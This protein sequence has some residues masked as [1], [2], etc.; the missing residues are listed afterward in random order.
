MLLRVA[1]E[2]PYT[3]FCRVSTTNG[4]DSSSG[5]LVALAFE[6]PAKENHGA[7]GY[8]HLLDADR[9]HQCRGRVGSRCEVGARLDMS[10][11]VACLKSR[12]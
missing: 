4:Q 9:A 12:N 7:R 2:S 11:L 6:G 5:V 3:T 10:S 1:R 8:G